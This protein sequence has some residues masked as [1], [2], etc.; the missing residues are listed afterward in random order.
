MRLCARILGDA[1]GLAVL[2][3]ELMGCD[4]RYK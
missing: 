1:R 2:D 4:S 3:R